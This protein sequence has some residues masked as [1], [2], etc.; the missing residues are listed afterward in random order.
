MLKMLQ[1]FVL[2]AIVGAGCKSNEIKNDS[3]ENAYSGPTGKPLITLAA[4]SA[5]DIKEGLEPTGWCYFKNDPSFQTKTVKSGEFETTS[6]YLDDFRTAEE[7]KNARVKFTTYPTFY[8]L[9]RYKSAHRKAFKNTDMYYGEPSD[10]EASPQNQFMQT[11]ALQTL[12]A[13]LTN[14]KLQEA[15]KQMA[16][17]LCDS[18]YLDAVDKIN[19]A[20]GGRIH[21]QD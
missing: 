15:Y 2:V 10:P 13:E 20:I 5:K 19:A 16:V 9:R 11:D 12:Q 8:T 7:M 6:E 3:E 21:H 1:C 18:A 17:S 4:V 14:L